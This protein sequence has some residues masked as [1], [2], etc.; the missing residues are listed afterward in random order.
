MPLAMPGA[1]RRLGS[2]RRC[3]RIAGAIGPPG[4]HAARNR[5][6]IRTRPSRHSSR[7]LRSWRQWKLLVGTTESW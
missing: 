7:I 5:K 4:R 6:R 1:Q 2:R 3:P